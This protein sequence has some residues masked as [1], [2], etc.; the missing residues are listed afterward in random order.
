[1]DPTVP[2]ARAGR[3]EAPLD[4]AYHPVLSLIHI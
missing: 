1:M 2:V 4:R 3:F